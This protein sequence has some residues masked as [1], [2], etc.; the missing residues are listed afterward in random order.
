MCLS[1]KVYI[2]FSNE[3]ILIGHNISMVLSLVPNIS[4]VVD[5]ATVVDRGQQSI[6]HDIFS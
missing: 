6:L 3:A 1:Q 4:V 5:C 2:N